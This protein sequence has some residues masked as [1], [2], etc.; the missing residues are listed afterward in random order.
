[1]TTQLGS[2]MAWLVAQFHGNLAVSGL[3]T[4]KRDEEWASL[5]MRRLGDNP[6]T[7]VQFKELIDGTTPIRGAVRSVPKTPEEYRIKLGSSTSA[8]S[9]TSP[10][11][12]G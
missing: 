1:M 10:K 12:L 2:Q 6:E 11:I 8:A 9:L 7:L 4:Q 3:T 5:P